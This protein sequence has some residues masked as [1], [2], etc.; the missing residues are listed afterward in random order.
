M[1]LV[2]VGSPP[3]RNF[4]F[5]RSLHKSILELGL[6]D[7]VIL[8]GHIPNDRIPAI[9]KAIDVYV[10]PSLREGTPVSILEAMAMEKAI[11]ATDVGGVRDQIING[12]TGLLIQPMSSKAIANAINSL[13]S[14][15]LLRA[16]LGRNARRHVEKNFS[17]AQALNQYRQ[18]YKR[19][20]N[21]EESV[22]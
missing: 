4:H 14:N 11:V 6:A 22:H 17:P 12:Q 5:F 3:W 19:H 1:K 16:K 15:P 8:T 9:L 20:W 13:F 7:E 21:K 10:L 2:I 18:L